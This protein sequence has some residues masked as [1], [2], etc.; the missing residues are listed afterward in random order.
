M[1]S[2]DFLIPGRI[3]LDIEAGSKKRVLEALA[4]LLQADNQNAEAIFDHLL[5]RERLGS[6]GMGHGIAL[7]HAR[8]DGLIEP[9][10]G[11]IRLSAGIDFGSIDGEPVDLIFGLLVPLQATQEHLQILAALA[12]LFRDGALCNKLRNVADA[13]GLLELLPTN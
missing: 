4:G 6:T 7:P 9:R 3:A 10:G 13:Q 8:M 5:E 11:F 1:F 12:S 2:A